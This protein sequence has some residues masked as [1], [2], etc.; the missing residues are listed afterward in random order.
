MNEVLQKDSFQFNDSIQKDN[1]IGFQFNVDVMNAFCDV[2]EE[3]DDT[4]V[5]S[6]L[7][8]GVDSA[9]IQNQKQRLL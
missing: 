4:I 7:V 6:P 1:R 9:S 3:C 8:L 2:I 5:P